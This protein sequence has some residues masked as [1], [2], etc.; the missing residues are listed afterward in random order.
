M[1]TPAVAISRLLA[2]TG[3]GLLLAVG[4]G[5]QQGTM[6]AQTLG[7]GHGFAIVGL[8][9]MTLGWQLANGTGALASRFSR[10]NDDEMSK[11][12]KQEMNEALKA[13]EVNNA[14][15]KLEATVLSME[16][17]EEE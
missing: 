8:V 4:F 13:E 10:E 2:G 6:E 5:L 7:V 17:G 12:V 14:W 15:A 16:L 11:R 3:V 9:C 1:H